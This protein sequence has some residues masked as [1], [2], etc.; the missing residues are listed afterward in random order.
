MVWLDAFTVEN[1]N[2]CTVGESDEK[3]KN[4]SVTFNKK[5]N[6][7]IKF[8]IDSQNQKH[9]Y[10][11]AESALPKVAD[12]VALTASSETVKVGDSVTLTAV[13]NSPASTNLTYTFT[14]TSGGDANETQNNDKLTV[15][16]TAA[17]TYKYTVTVSAGGYSPVTST[18]VS[19]T[20]TAPVT[21]YLGGRVVQKSENSDWIAP[22][23]TTNTSCKF[24]ETET[25]G[26]YKYESEQTPAAWSE[27]RNNLLQYFYVRTSLGGALYYGNA[28]SGND[29]LAL[30]AQ[31][32]KANLAEIDNTDVKNLIYIN[33]NDTS[34]NATFWLDTRNNKYKLWYTTTLPHNY[35][36]RWCISVC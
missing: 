14:K 3:Y 15:T 2:G 30:T 32:Q 36:S 8:N 25:D 4:I 19:F 34:I 7:T 11:I 27:K 26:L 23:S 1:G 21:Y 13:A 18:E 16:P 20:V 22:D 29:A 24:V 17:G 6:V 12:S 31:G 35:C 28:E 5:S 10:V 33:S 9:L